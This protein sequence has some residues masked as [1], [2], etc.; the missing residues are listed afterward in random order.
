MLNGE[1]N[2]PDPCQKVQKRAD[3]RRLVVKHAPEGNTTSQHITKT[4]GGSSTPPSHICASKN[5]NMKIT[6]DF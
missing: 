5:E 1:N 3:M 6:P 4:G 2:S